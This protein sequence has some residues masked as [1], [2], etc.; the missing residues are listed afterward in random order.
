[1]KPD[2]TVG[3]TRAAVKGYEGLYEVDIYGNVYSMLHTSSRRKGVL[4]P[5][6]HSGS[7][8]RVNLYD[9]DGKCSKKYVHR[10]VAEAFI[11]NSQNKPNINHIDCNGENNNVFN[12]EWCTQSEI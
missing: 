4:K 2:R 10:L 8:R 12:L 7:C 3:R 1:M 5:Y 9:W 11:P 6:L